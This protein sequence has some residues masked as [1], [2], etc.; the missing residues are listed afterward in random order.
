MEVEITKISEKGQI[1]IPS[2]LRKEMGIK[3]A[4]KFLLFGEG[5]TIIIKKIEEPAFKKS[6]AEIA[7]PLQKATAKMGFTRADV[8]RAIQEARRKHA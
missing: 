6:F 8:K 4:D 2:S 5:S 3:K 1:V 7:K